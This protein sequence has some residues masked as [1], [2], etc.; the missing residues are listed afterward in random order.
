M[1]ES[2]CWITEMVCAHLIKKKLP[3]DEKRWL[4]AC[5]IVRKREREREIDCQKQSNVW[6]QAEYK[7]V[8]TYISEWMKIQWIV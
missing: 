1:E 4:W 2:V 7:T 5:F 3:S 6:K 8:I